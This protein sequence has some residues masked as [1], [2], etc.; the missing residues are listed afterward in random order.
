[1]PKLSE[2]YE[3][4]YNLGA[5]LIA[6]YAPLPTGAD[7]CVVEADGLYGVFFDL[8]QLDT[9][10]KERAAASHEWAHIATGA[11]YT[12]GATPSVVQ[13]AERRATRAQIKKLLPFPE[14]RAAMEGG[15][16]EPYQLAE[17]F[18]V[19]EDLIQQAVDYYTGPCGLSFRD[20][21][22]NCC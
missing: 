12:M 4:L 1:M 3:D 11:T 18:E 5:V 21:S 14:M 17:H 19:P 13:A 22:E 8:N 2:I 16:T 10:S 7:A 15:Y 9:I 20:P 6:E